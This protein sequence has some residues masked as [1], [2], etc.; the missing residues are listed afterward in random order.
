MGLNYDYIL[1]FER[2][3]LWNALDGLVAITDHHEPPTTINFPD[4]KIFVP[5]VS[6]KYNNNQFNYNDPEFSFATSIYFHLDEE[7][8]EYL[9]I[10]GNEEEFRGPPDLE[11]TD[12]VAIGYIYLTI[13][14]DLSS[15]FPGKKSDDFV[16]FKFG[17]TGTKM[18]LLFD[19]SPSIRKTFCQLLES[20]PGLYGIFSREYEGEL[21]WYKGQPISKDI[22]EVYILPV[23][24]EQILNDPWMR[25]K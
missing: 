25:D 14:N 1:Y 7:I 18:S 9:R 15:W 17:T 12:R 21:F 24:L 4:R 11:S 22:G 16:L 8:L 2:K 3:H 19:A 23:E 20:V 13:Y 6:S 10:I 5:L